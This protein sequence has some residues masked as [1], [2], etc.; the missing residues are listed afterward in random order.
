MPWAVIM[1]YLQ[2]QGCSL[3]FYFPHHFIRFNCSI[4]SSLRA[5]NHMVTISTPVS[6]SRLTTFPMGNRYSALS[7]YF[8][9]PYTNIIHPKAKTDLWIPKN[10]YSITLNLMIAGFGFVCSQFRA[11]PG[12]RAIELHSDREL[13]ATAGTG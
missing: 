8:P 3:M 5:W 1:M 13:P 9:K 12:G 4:K 10:N 6:H 7:S 2:C 11:Q